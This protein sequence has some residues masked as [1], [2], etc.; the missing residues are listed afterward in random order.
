MTKLVNCELYYI[1]CDPKFPNRK[2]NKENPTWDVQIRT[3]DINQKREWDM[4]G[5]RTKLMVHSEGDLEG[6]P[7]L[8]DDGKK[9]WKA[10]LR[11][12]TIKK[13]GS[14][15]DPVEVV[16]AKLRPIDPNTIGNGSIGD[17]L[18]YQ[19]DIPKPTDG[20][21]VANILIGIQVKKHIIYHPKSIGESF[22][23]LDEPTVKIKI[24]SE[25]HDEDSE[26]VPWD[27][28][29]MYIPGDDDDDDQ[30]S[31]YEDEET[32][33]SSKKKINQSYKPSNSPAPK[34]APPLKRR[35]PVDEHPEDAF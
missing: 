13:D 29:N 16:D 21:K 20:N 5:I 18:V 30:D 4:K 25:E 12:K 24:E 7:I 34:S 33:K 15:A 28:D 26:D 35:K 23:E 3:T 11:K 32:S 2:F 31:E 27:E 10:T 17:V 9:Q 8:T 6:T 1:K 19:Y 14:K 22:G